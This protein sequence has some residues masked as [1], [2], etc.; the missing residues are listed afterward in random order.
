MVS[1]TGL[2]LSPSSRSGV[3]GLQDASCLL[4]VCQGQGHA[5]DFTQ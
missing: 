4:P 3:S 2:G 5:T 1:G